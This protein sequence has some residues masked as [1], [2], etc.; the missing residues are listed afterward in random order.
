M[1]WVLAL[2][3]PMMVALALSGCSDTGDKSKVAAGP[4]G[5]ATVCPGSTRC[6]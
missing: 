6:G 5:S 4:A 2:A 3:L 1:K